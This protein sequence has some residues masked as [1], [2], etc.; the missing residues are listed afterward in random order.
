MSV[1]VRHH[2]KELTYLLTYMTAATSLSIFFH[3][4]IN[5]ISLFDTLAIRGGI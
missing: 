4:L 3:I 1:F 5:K 2:N